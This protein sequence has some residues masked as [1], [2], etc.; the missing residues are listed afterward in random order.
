MFWLSDLT[1]MSI[2]NCGEM[3]EIWLDEP[4]VHS[5]IPPESGST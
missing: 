4:N 5:R 3:V 1:S 2:A